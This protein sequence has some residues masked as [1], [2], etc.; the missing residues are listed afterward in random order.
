MSL[1]LCDSNEWALQLM[2]QPSLSFRYRWWRC[3]YKLPQKLFALTLSY[4]LLITSSVTHFSTVVLQY[5]FVVVIHLCCHCRYNSSQV[6]E[7]PASSLLPQLSSSGTLTQV[8]AGEL[9]CS[10]SQGPMST[11]PA[12]QGASS[13][14]VMDEPVPNPNF[15]IL[16]A[17]MGW[18]LLQ[19]IFVRENGE[20][21]GQ[22]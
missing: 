8:S 17:K 20:K 4:Q 5:K 22:D 10:L 14:W 15:T 18:F 16:K 1:E 21:A 7:I 12:S 9:T 19:E 11:P 6:F 3:V 2:V 13:G